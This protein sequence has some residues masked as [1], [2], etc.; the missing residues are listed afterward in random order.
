M[1]SV[2]FVTFEIGTL[3]V[4]VLYGLL[5][6]F[7]F[8]YFGWLLDILISDFNYGLILVAFRLSLDSLEYFQG[9]GTFFQ[10]SLPLPTPT[11]IQ[12][13]RMTTV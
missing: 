9:K 6:S 2:S 5:E 10:P 7:F 12:R 8:K 3:T 11:S 1:L 13:Y 4:L